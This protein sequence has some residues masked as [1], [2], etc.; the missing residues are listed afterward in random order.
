MLGMQEPAV[1]LT[2]FLI[3]VECLVLTVLIIRKKSRNINLKS[4]V[5]LFFTSIGLVALLGGIVHG[6]FPEDLSSLSIGFW[7]VLLTLLGLTALSIWGIIGCFFNEKYARAIF[8]F[9]VVEFILYI[10]VLDFTGGKFS[11][12]LYNYLLPV[13]LLYVILLV[14]FYVRKGHNGLGFGS[15]G[16]LLAFAGALVQQA[17]L[18]LHQLYFDYNTFYHVIQFFSLLCMFIAFKQLIEEKKLS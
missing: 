17:Q 10:F 2:A 5:V 14:S 12:A 1:A 16:I 13:V 6:Y 4:F 3:F 15:L 8:Y 11:M 7:K 9:S 18:S